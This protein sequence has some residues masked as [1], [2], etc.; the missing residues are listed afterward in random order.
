VGYVSILPVLIASE[1]LRL[2]AG[3]VLALVSVAWYIGHQRVPDT[4]PE[5][6]LAQLTVTWTFAGLAL[7]VLGGAAFRLPWKSLTAA[8]GAVVLAVVVA[9]YG[10]RTE[11]IDAQL[12]RSSEA[13]L[14]RGVSCPTCSGVNV[15]DYRRAYLG[16]LNAERARGVRCPGRRLFTTSRWDYPLDL[17]S[18]RFENLL[19]D[20]RGLPLATRLVERARPGTLPCDYV[21]AA[22]AALD[23]SNGVPL[24]RMLQEQGRLEPVAEAGPYV[25]FAAR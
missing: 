9:T 22:R 6:A 1:R 13:E 24:V 2:G 25:V 23:T 17:Q 14:D 15:S 8:A 16:L 3:A 20:V 11:R 10:P 18:T 5:E 19:F 4:P 12:V 21:I 7:W